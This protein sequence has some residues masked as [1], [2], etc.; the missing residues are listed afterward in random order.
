MS[1]A[2]L[3]TRQRSIDLYRLIKIKRQLSF[4]LHYSFVASIPTVVRELYHDSK[5]CGGE[6][7]YRRC[8]CHGARVEGR[9]VWRY[10]ITRADSL[11]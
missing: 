7:N 6:E 11:L 10:V 4:K 5:A 3:F 1:E 8:N 9:S 2:V